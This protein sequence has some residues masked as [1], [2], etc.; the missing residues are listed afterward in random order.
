MNI[1]QNAWA[2]LTHS[3]RKIGIKHWNWRLYTVSYV[4]LRSR[5]EN[6]LPSS[7]QE[8]F[9]AQHRHCHAVCNLLVHPPTSPCPSFLLTQN[10]S[11]WDIA[12][13][14]IM[15]LK[16]TQCIYVSLVG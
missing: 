3:S 13:Y 1:D 16:L 5:Q 9:T 14:D 2:M 6:G 7:N 15:K 10:Q 11:P 8:L 12:G 4:H